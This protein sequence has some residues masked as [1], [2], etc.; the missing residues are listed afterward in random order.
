[1]EGRA[2]KS[3]A[4]AET[5]RQRAADKEAEAIAQEKLARRRFYAAQ[6]NLALQALQAG[7][8]ARV[9]EL[10]ENHRPRFDEE[11]LRGFE[12]YY[13]WGKCHR[14]LR[15][16]LKTDGPTAAVAFA[17]DSRTVAVGDKDGTVTLFD[18]QNGTFMGR[19]VSPTNFFPWVRLTFSPD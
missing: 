19:L 9:L 12:W 10:L 15:T 2:K 6:M 17:P 16:W 5:E 1:Q 7:N 4:T 3:A 11:D 18:A 8:T 14:G 13:L